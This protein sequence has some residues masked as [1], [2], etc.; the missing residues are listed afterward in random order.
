M[1]FGTSSTSSV[2]QSSGGLGLNLAK[3]INEIVQNRLRYSPLAENYRVDIQTEPSGG[4]RIVV[5]NQIY[6]SADDV[7]N[8]EVKDLIKASIKEWESR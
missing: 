5:N 2:G 4:I 6:S 7:P 1:S 8:A 3:E